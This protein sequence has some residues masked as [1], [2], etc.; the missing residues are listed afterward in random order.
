[1]NFTH[2]AEKLFTS[3]QSISSQISNLERDLDCQLFVRNHT[4][5]TLTE[6]GKRYYALFS[7]AILRGRTLL[8]QLH[9]SKLHRETHLRLGIS[10]W[11]DITGKLGAC[12]A[13]FE[14]MFPHITIEPLRDHNRTLL[15]Q[16]KQRELDLLLLGDWHPIGDP[17]L[18]CTAISK[19][20]VCL[21]VP[22]DVSDAAPDAGCWG[23]PLYHPAAWD[24]GLFESSRIMEHR[25]KELG[26]SPKITRPVHNLNSLRLQLAMGR[27]V[28]LCEK[29]LCLEN[30]IP[31]CRVFPLKETEC[32]C[33]QHQNNVTEVAKLFQQFARDYF[34]NLQTNLV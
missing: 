7:D 24:F 26:L 27:C 16:L 28:V 17:A 3:Q 14:K 15:I 34:Y 33:L 1:M 32:Y 31:G 8:N 23:L 18:I 6:A 21:Y 19:Q 29:E 11:L 30:N 12:F 9:G 2:A 22:E 20:T 4:N 13:A 5:V 10:K 25:L